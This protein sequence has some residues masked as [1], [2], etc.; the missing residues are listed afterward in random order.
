MKNNMKNKSYFLFRGEK[1]KE[2]WKQIHLALGSNILFSLLFSESRHC[3]QV[4][5]L[6]YNQFGGTEMV[7][8]IAIE[9]KSSTL[10]CRCL[11][12]KKKQ[13][14]QEAKGACEDKPANCRAEGHLL[15]RSSHL[16]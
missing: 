14:A 7:I 1:K 2:E 13:N 15:M 8:Q 6:Y 11:K 9:K 10:K 12:K 5:H 4:I 3:F 16:G